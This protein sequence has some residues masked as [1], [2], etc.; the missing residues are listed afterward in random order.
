M[1]NQPVADPCCGLHW[2]CDGCEKRVMSTGVK[3]AG[4]SSDKVL[5]CGPMPNVM[6]A[7]LNIGGALCESSIIP[8]VVPRRT[9]ADVHCSSAMQ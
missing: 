7:L 4:H 1:Y 6:A 5:E 9:L 8:F 2:F 3:T